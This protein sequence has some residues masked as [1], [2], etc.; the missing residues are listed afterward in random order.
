MTPTNMPATL[1][2]F[3][4]AW[5]NWKSKPPPIR[6]FSMSAASTEKLIRIVSSVGIRG[7]AL[8]GPKRHDSPS[9]GRSEPS[10]RIRDQPLHS[11][12]VGSSRAEL[13]SASEGHQIL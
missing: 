12:L 6:H 11:F 5:K 3:M 1:P 8:L 4:R 10:K 13:H 2:G 7:I 9:R